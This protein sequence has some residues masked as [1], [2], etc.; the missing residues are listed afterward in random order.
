MAAIA[1]VCSQ[2]FW[3]TGDFRPSISRCTDFEMHELVKSRPIRPQKAP[4]S[5]RELPNSQAEGTA[6][7]VRRSLELNEP[8]LNP[9][10]RA[11]RRGTR[12]INPLSASGPL[13][14]RRA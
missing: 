6:C 10:V 12:P 9:G 14:E 8:G 13:Q 3:K 7:H 4:Y 5:L 11:R 1:P 2:A